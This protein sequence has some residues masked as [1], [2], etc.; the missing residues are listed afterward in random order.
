MDSLSKLTVT[1]MRNGEKFKMYYPIGS[2][3]LSTVYLNSTHKGLIGDD[4]AVSFC[5]IVAL[6]A[7]KHDEYPDANPCA[8]VMLEYL[9]KATVDSH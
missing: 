5:N 7:G 6:Y 2:S 8:S 3:I 1:L 4:L 9:L